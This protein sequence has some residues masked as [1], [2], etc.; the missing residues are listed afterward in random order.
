MW[1][2][3][4]LLGRPR[5]RQVYDPVTVQRNVAESENVLQ[6]V[7][8]FRYQLLKSFSK[9]YY[10]ITM[11]CIL[12][13]FF[14]APDQE[15]KFLIHLSIYTSLI[16]SLIIIVCRSCL[17]CLVKILIAAVILNGVVNRIW[18]NRIG[19]ISSEKVRINSIQFY[20]VIVTWYLSILKIKFSKILWF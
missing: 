5:A 12:I 3:R 11:I 9:R 18:I 15:I 2:N 8:L 19:L 6:I 20:L 17:E 13:F 1:T 14:F 4:W 10:I 16:R 7:K